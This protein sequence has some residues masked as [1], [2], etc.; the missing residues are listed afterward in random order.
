MSKIHLSFS[1]HGPVLKKMSIVMAGDAPQI[2]C[3]IERNG[4]RAVWLSISP[5]WCGAYSTRSRMT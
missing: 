5:I 4:K 1:G 3:E 2:K